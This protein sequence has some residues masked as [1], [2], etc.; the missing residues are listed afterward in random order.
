MVGV[1][2]EWRLWVKMVVQR[3]QGRVRWL[4]LKMVP[5]LGVEWSLWMKVMVHGV[6]LEWSLRANLILMSFVKMVNLDWI[7]L[8]V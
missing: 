3:V 2:V 4:G 8:L 6:R 7:Q 1:G 5:G